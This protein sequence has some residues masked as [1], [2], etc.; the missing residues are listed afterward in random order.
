MFLGIL[1]G[2]LTRIAE[3]ID[4]RLAMT[5]MEKNC[6]FGEG[7]MDLVRSKEINELLV[8]LRVDNDD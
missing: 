4:A 6:I 1:T 8:G 7:L 5:V 2:E 3:I